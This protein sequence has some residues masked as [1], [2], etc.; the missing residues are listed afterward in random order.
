MKALK[1]VIIFL[2][3]VSSCL[4]DYSYVFSQQEKVKEIVQLKHAEAKT[5]VGML[6]LM[7][8]GIKAYA[9]EEL[10]A[11]EIYDSAGLVKGVLPLILYQL[12]LEKKTLFSV[13][14]PRILP[15][16][17]RQENCAALFH[18][19]ASAISQL[20]PALPSESRTSSGSENHL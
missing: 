19:N 7:L 18:C 15:V 16:S 17:C 9:N 14:R 13:H 20:L 10:N 12:Y 2:F 6:Q 3:I 5:V 11:V 8:P 4:F 1:A